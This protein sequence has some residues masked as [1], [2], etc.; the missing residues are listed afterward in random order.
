MKSATAISYELD[1]IKFAAGELVSQIKEK[2][3]FEKNTIAI[4]HGQP[5]M[6]LEG[7]SAAVGQALNCQVFGGTTAAGAV[8]TNEG[9]HE[10]AVVLHVLSADD[11]TF[12]AAI[13]GS[14]ETDPEKEIKETYQAAYLKLKEQDKSADPKMIICAASIVQSYSSDDILTKITEICGDIPVFGYNAGDDFEFCKQQVFLNGESGGDRLAILLVSGNIQPIFHTANLAGRKALDKSRVTKAQGNVIYEI[15]GKPAYEYIKEFPFIDDETS[16]LF[17]YQFFVGLQNDEYNDD[18]PVS[19]AL[20]S[21]DK[22]AGTITCFAKIPQDSYIGLLYCDGNDVAA[23]SEAALKEFSDKLKTAGNDYEYSNALIVSCSL[24]NMFLAEMRDKEG[25][26]IEEFLP[27]GL[28][29]S[30]LHAFGEIAPT[31]IGNGKAANRFHNAT[32]T[33]CAF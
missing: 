11:C 12:A 14:M 5:D 10:L 16:T 19:R 21:F 6:D 17:N 13:S 29:A 32:F 33:I 3:T 7:L 4:L 20:N 1:D 30:G 23:T 22:E 27:K 2:I 31:G 8:F 9:Y 26:I 18:V 24:R 28:I 25:Q 15:E